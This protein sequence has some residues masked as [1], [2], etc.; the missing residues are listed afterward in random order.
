MSDN[1]DPHSV[2]G[3]YD[4]RRRFDDEMATQEYYAKQQEN[5]NRS[6]PVG[7]HE[8]GLIGGFFDRLFHK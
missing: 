1:V 5:H 6:Y 8:P 2:E 7:G 3:W 4:P